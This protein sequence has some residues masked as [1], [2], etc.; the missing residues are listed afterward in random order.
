M[1]SI[2]HDCIARLVIMPNVTQVVKHLNSL[3]R[4]I[5]RRL[6]LT[7]PACLPFLVNSSPMFR[8]NFTIFLI[9]K[10][11]LILF[12]YI[13]IIH[14]NKNSSIYMYIYLTMYAGMHLCLPT[15]C[16]ITGMLELK[17]K[18]AKMVKIMRSLP[19]S[20]MALVWLTFR[21]SAS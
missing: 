6:K 19:N 11:L 3:I 4:K 15:S 1:A 5:N 21:F 12:K 18:V 16:A 14:Q 13:Q 9:T 2:L 7:L 10:L 8:S 17:R 20:I